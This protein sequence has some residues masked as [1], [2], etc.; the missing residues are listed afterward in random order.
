[1]NMQISARYLQ[2]QSLYKL[3]SSLC[4]Q[5]QAEAAVFADILRTDK[6]S[7]AAAYTYQN[8]S[9]SS[10]YQ[11]GS[12]D[13][14]SSHSGNT[15]LKTS[16]INLGLAKQMCQLLSEQNGSKTLCSQAQALQMAPSSNILLMQ[17][18]LK[19]SLKDNLFLEKKTLEE[20]TMLCTLLK[21]ITSGAATLLNLGQQ[22]T[23]NPIQNHI[24]PN[25]LPLCFL[26]QIRLITLRKLLMKRKSFKERQKEQE[27]KQENERHDLMEQFC[28]SFIRY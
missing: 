2:Q 26:A 18:L 15:K 7:D 6:K 12:K 13:I 23:L 21:K 10:E 22:M 11:T 14:P 16:L 25:F 19:I 17:H 28:E 8:R 4:R 20:L 9:A 3:E 24:P 1:M 27:R 5:A